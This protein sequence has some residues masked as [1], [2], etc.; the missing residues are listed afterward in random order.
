MSIPQPPDG[1]APGISGG[2]PPHRGVPAHLEAPTDEPVAPEASAPQR[3]TA[4][5]RGNAPAPEA[6]TADAHGDAPAEEPTAA[7]ART[8]QQPTAPAG[9]S[10]PAATNAS[11]APSSPAAPTG[12]PGMPTNCWPTVEGVGG[13]ARPFHRAEDFPT[14]AANDGRSAWTIG[15]IVLV[16]FFGMLI[17]P[18]VMLITAT[19]NRRK[20]PVAAHVSRNVMIFAGITLALLVVALACSVVSTFYSDTG[21][22]LPTWLF[23]PLVPSLAWS[24]MIAPL[25]TLIMGII[26]LLRP[27]SREKAA[28]ILATHRKAWRREDPSARSPAG[29]PGPTRPAAAAPARPPS[30]RPGRPSTAPAAPPRSPLSPTPR[31]A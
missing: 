11:A 6:A 17:A 4:D 7:G 2:T 1:E 15:L 20:N 13:T 5:S 8:A 23:I 12:G 25:V 22:Q 9:P 10:N 14:T 31:T 29:T 30:H 19:S 24:M 21:A 16:P 28:K 3:P 18:L 26:A 27:V